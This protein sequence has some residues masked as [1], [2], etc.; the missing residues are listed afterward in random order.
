MNAPIVDSEVELRPA[1]VVGVVRDAPDHAVQAQHVLREEGQ[2]GA[3]E[4]EPELDLAQALV[5]LPAGHLGEPVEQ[6]REDREHRARHE[7][8][9][10]VADDPV[11]VLDHEV[12]GH[13]RQERAIEATDEEQRDEAAPRT[14]SGCRT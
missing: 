13:H 12:E 2:V 10:D 9:V 5:Q 1:G 4:Q 7:H 6:R 11:G 8:V 14:A 3:D